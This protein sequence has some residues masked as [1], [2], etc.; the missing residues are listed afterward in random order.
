VTGI[1][2]IAEGV[3]QTVEKLNTLSPFSFSVLS[4]LLTSFSISFSV[5]DRRIRRKR[6]KDKRPE[7]VLHRGDG[8]VFQSGFGPIDL[9]IF[10]R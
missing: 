10:V 2:G 1:E 6:E 3:L 4:F 9:R 5:S 8:V 7:F